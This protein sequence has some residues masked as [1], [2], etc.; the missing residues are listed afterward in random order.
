MILMVDIADYFT[1]KITR[2]LRQNV[3]AESEHL[4]L[5]RKSEC[6]LVDILVFFLNSLLC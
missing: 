1:N 6:E 5:L 4:A 2:S 3:I